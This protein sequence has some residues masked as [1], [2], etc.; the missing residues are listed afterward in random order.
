MGS[1]ESF[2]L[3]LAGRMKSLLA[4]QWPHCSKRVSEALC[5]VDNST[6]LYMVN[7]I[8]ALGFSGDS[9]IKNLPANAGNTTD[10]G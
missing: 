8:L 4:V 9:V 7:E 3:L 5:I 6:Y 1:G 2:C 10:V